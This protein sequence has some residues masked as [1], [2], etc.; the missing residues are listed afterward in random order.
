MKI[1]LVTHH[2]HT[3]S[4]HSKSS[5]Y[6]RIA[7]YLAKNNNIDVLTCGADNYL[8]KENN[9]N[10]IFKKGPSSNIFFEK[11]LMLSYR[12]IKIA[13]NYD[14]IHCLYSDPG[15]LL[16]IKYPIITTEHNLPEI[17]NSLW[18]KYKS[19]IQK[20]TLKKSKLIIAVSDNL[21][22]II[23]KKYNKNTIFIPHGVDIHSFKP[24]HFSIKEKMRIT[25]NKFKYISLSCGIQGVNSD[26]FQKVTERFPEILFIVVGRKEKNNKVKNIINLQNVSEKDLIFYYQISDFCFKPLKFA[27]AN[28]AVLEA[29][30]MEKVTLTNKIPGITD[31]LDEKCSYLAKNNEE[32]YTL[33]KLM[34]KNPKD[35]FQ[36]E[37]NAREKAINFFSWETISNKILHIYNEKN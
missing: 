35:K 28:N 29:M 8:K 20:P 1:L 36:K 33:I 22:S 16:S 10:I 2:W 14:L 7:Y 30:A 3:N 12:A 31:Y 34:I 11:R 17:D 25:K 32:F 37:K 9:I 24:G 23:K 4:H 5:G 21:K 13:K 27:T 15:F 19:I 18:M 6:E 26:V